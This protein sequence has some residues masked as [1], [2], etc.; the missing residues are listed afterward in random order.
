V[1]KLFDNQ[2]ALITGAASGIGLSCAVMLAQRG[3]KVCV[4]DI[5]EQ[6]A[7]NAADQINRSGGEAMYLG[8]DVTSEEAN[9]CAVEKIIERYGRLDIAHLNAGVLSLS[10][11]MDCSVDDWKRVI[12]INLNAVFLGLRACGSPM[13][14]QGRGTIVVTASLAGILGSKGMPAYIA[15]KH[16]AV[17]L[18][19]AA[20][21]EWGE[22]GI[23]V[24]A[25][26]PGATYT[27]MLI[28]QGSY[29]QV[30]QSALI[31]NMMLKR[32]AKPDEVAELVSF[33]VSDAASYITGGIYPVDG[34]MP[35]LDR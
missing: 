23:R 34:G 27:D 32:V 7:A 26:C 21:A 31:N 20:A 16:G 17:G 11:I 13:L 12:D 19:K 35:V 15:S 28:T 2:V 22:A 25:I 8:M 14:Q 18:V 29:E 9:Q 5:N 3:A 6:G 4:A 24:N 10:S 1:E 30:N 33:L